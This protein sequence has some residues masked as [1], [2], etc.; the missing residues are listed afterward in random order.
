[1]TAKALSIFFLLPVACTNSSVSGQRP[2][3]AP[4]ATEIVGGEKVL[5]KDRGHSI[6]DYAVS[7]AGL[8]A[9]AEGN[10]TTFSSCTGSLIERDLVLTAAHCLER[11]SSVD[12]LFVTLDEQV[13]LGFSKQIGVKAYVV[14]PDTA[15][16]YYSDNDV[17]LLRL[18][19]PAPS[20]KKTVNLPT[21]ELSAMLESGTAATAVGFG[22][23]QGTLNPARVETEISL[24]STPIDV[25]L[26][27]GQSVWVVDQRLGR[28]LCEGDSG[29]PL[30]VKQNSNYTVLGVAHAVEIAHISPELR[31]E[32]D[33]EG[34]SLETYLASHPD[35]DMCKDQGQYTAVLPLIPWI[36]KAKAT[37]P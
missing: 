7:V 19:S 18:K 15:P 26:E 36:L 31:A 14:H 11:V 6:G 12:D 3:E 17:A 16:Y 20:W 24:R 27:K 29:G 30:L 33:K 1:M 4:A 35:V 32:M 2:V 23:T 37:I 22:K 8:I 13:I 9:D 34:F 25:K 5:Y 21:A 28:G 10:K